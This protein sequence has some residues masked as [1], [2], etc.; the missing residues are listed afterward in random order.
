[1]KTKVFVYR[2]KARW[3]RLTQPLREVIE[4]LV[5]RLKLAAEDAYDQQSW[6]N[7]WPVAPKP[8]SKRIR[9]AV[10][11]ALAERY[12]WRGHPGRYEGCGS[13]LIGEW[14]WDLSMDGG[15]DADTGDTEHGGWH[16]LFYG[17]F[18][19]DPREDIAIILTQW[20][21]GAIT[22]GW[23]ATKTEADEVFEAASREYSEAMSLEEPE[24]EDEDRIYDQM[25]D[26]ILTGDAPLR[27]S[28]RGEYIA[29]DL[30]RV[31]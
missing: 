25:R 13:Q 18:P 16:A 3:A 28:T 7:R 29:I 30:D 8:L 21:S 20:S 2:M 11:L 5:W 1:M 14:L 24:G 19:W 4:R 23:Y 15:Q 17:P 26:D 10:L 12:D 22:Y 9:R 27:L 6:E 31:D